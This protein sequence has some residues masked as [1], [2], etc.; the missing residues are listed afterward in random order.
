L[1]SGGADKSVRLW[2]AATGKELRRFEG[3]D[4]ITDL[5]FSSDGKTL[6]AKEG[7]KGK[8]SWDVATRKEV[9]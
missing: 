8:R 4:E 9:K 3:K 6:T 7:A 1:A 5:S 2:D